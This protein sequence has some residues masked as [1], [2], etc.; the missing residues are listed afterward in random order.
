MFA[1]FF[2]DRPILSTV[3]SVVIVIV[4]LVALRGLPIS[5]YP[6][7]VPPTIQVLAQYPGASAEVVAETVALPIA[8]EVNGV[9][10]MLYMQ[11]ASSNDGS[12]GLSVVFK[13]GTPLDQAQVLTQNRVAAAEARL[14]ED[15]RRL[16]ITTKKRS[17]SMLMVIN[18]ISPDGSRDDLYLGNY[19]AIQV[20]EELARVDGVGDVLVFGARDYSM[21]IWLDPEKLASRSLAADDVVR[22]LREQN[23]QVAAGRIGQP[24]VPKGTPFQY[25]INAL[26]RLVDADQFGD[27]ILKAGPTGETVKLRDVARIELGARNSDM[28]SY[29]DNQPSVAMG[30]FQLP[31]SNALATAERVRATMEHLKSRFPSGVEYRVGYDTTV[32]VAESV[33]EVWKTLVEAFLLV[34]IVVLVF[35]Q[36]WRPTLLP[37]IDVPVSL[38][39]TFAVMAALGFSLNNLSLF[40][41]VLAIGIVVD[42]AIVVVENIERWMRKGY[43]PREATYH[44]MREITGPVLAITLVLASV[45]IPTAFLSGISGQFYRQ[46][47]L[48][49]A[50]ATLISAI[51]ALTMAPSRAVQIIRVGPDPE[52]EHHEALPRAGYV[53]V[54]GGLATLLLAPFASRWFGASTEAAHGAAAHA[55]SAATW[56]ARGVAVAVGGLAGWLVAPAANRAMSRFFAAFNRFFARFTALYGRLLARV[57]RYAAVGMVIYAVLLGLGYVAFRMTPSGFIPEQDKGYVIAVVQLPDGASL[58]RTD[59]VVRRATDIAR[60]APGVSHVVGFPGFS[61]LSGSTLPNSAVMFIVLNPFEERVRAGQG[62]NKVLADL[63]MRLMAIEDGF[64]LA[65]GA[66]VVDGLGTVGGFKMQ[67]Q[68]RGATGPKA[69]QAAVEE[70]IGRASREPGLVGLFSGFRA[71]QPQLFAEVDRDKAKSLGVPLA[72]VFDTLQIQLGSLYVNDFTRFGRNWQVLVQ[73]DAPFRVR[74]EDIQRL[75][76]RNSTGEMVPLGTLVSVRDTTGPASVNHYNL[77]PSADLTGSTLP[78]VSTKQA[79]EKMERLARE[80]LPADKTFEWTELSLQEILEKNTAP[81]A[82]ALGTLFVFLVLAALYE[83][84]SLPLS[85]VM[86][87]P[88]CLVSAV[89]SLLV[90]R[91]QNDIFAQIGFVVLIGLAAKNAILIVEFAREREQEGM[92]RV[93]AA[94]EAARVRLRPILM[95]S[96]A[97]A[98][99]VLPLIT[100]KGAGA[101]MRRSLG[102]AVFGGMVGVTLFGLVFTPIFYVVIRGLAA[103]FTSPAE[104]A[105]NASAS[106]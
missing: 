49:I 7:V 25:P 47:A 34:F 15:V 35:L 19:A 29:I 41:L 9:E 60:A 63:R 66:P 51:N 78:G 105:A 84:W 80:V 21:R 103:R 88:M 11:S 44:A 65:F 76:V 5:Q 12:M 53:L 52:K 20:R 90:M 101:E 36:D 54:V 48:T 86:I 87:V 98:L 89:G 99:G 91:M 32:F 64:V 4:G 62:V 73:A 8:Q 10:N 102:V 79:I 30:I 97:F 26:G 61:I 31:G 74:P 71:G 58:E 14:P 72:N 59:A 23:I 46:F 83:S 92:S 27:V 37:M 82:F 43:A 104:P 56:W 2:I 68:D 22:A 40:G 1:R 85:I 77:F 18:L 6:N 81:M 55:S 96:L 13:L 70:L 28:S 100:S 57:L 38:I 93:Q 95:T 17:P 45:F 16:G 50:S 24:P 75:Q 67:V 94:I 33:R 42:D 106:P 3:L 69:L 39:G